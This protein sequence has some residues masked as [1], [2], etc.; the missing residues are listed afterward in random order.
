M[1]AT[2][3]E[4]ASGIALAC[5]VLAVAGV[6]QAAVNGLPDAV[7]EA[8]GKAFPGATI[9]SVDRETEKGVRY[10]EINLLRNGMRI[11][12][13]VDE[14]GGI[15]EIE[16]RIEIN[17]APREVRDLVANAIKSG[18]RAR[19]ERHERWGVARN[20]RFVKLDKPRVF[21]EIK[22]YTRGGRRELK[23]RPEG[24]LSVPDKIAA[25]IKT[26]FPG[27][28]VTD[29]E[30]EGEGG[31]LLY[32]ASIVHKGQDIEL[33]LSAAGVLIEVERDVALKD[34]P[35]PVTRALQAAA[36]GATV[37][38]AERAEVRAVI[39]D[40]KIQPRKRPQVVY[41][42]RL[43]KGGLWAE[44]S[45]AETGAVLE[46]PEWKKTEDDDDD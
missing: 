34:L 21:Y 5:F 27:A 17:E 25:A 13:E 14:D 24:R 23:W 16:R 29:I 7:R 10:Y 11:E 30:E 37:V 39:K 4:R 15:G 41:E 32:E 38:G 26:A 45:F 20:G 3:R 31:A 9:R 12:V 22:L 6:A 46:K 2:S 42:I 8:V 28:V 44:A 33:E 35:G 19:V 36:P 40:G 43:R 1:K 18:G